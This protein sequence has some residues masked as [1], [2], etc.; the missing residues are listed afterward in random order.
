MKNYLKTIGDLI[1]IAHI[2]SV[3]FLKCRPKLFDLHF[4]K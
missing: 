4:L 1:K 3:Y 2:A